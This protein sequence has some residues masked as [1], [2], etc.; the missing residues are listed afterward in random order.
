MPFRT[1]LDVWHHT[2]TSNAIH[3][4]VSGNSSLETWAYEGGRQGHPLWDFKMVRSA[5]RLRKGHAYKDSE[6]LLLEI[7]EERGMGRK[8]RA[9]LRNPGYIPETLFY[10][11]IGWPERIVLN[12]P[13]RERAMLK[14]TR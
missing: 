9:W 8:C 7:A 1:F 5:G 13:Q 14:L 4:I 10:A 11:V 12:D 3:D 2:T 6:K